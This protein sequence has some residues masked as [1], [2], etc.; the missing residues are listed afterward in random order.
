[1]FHLSAG[2]ARA[3]LPLS[4]LNDAGARAVA[5]F[6]VL[7]CLVLAVLSAQR[8]QGPTP[9]PA[10]S[11]LS[12]FSAQR[13]LRHVDAIARAPHP[14]GSAAHRQVRDYLQATLRDMGLQVETQSALVANRYRPTGM[15][16]VFAPV[17]NIVATLPGNA[18]TPGRQADSLLLMA[19]YD[20]AH[21]TP[22][23]SDDAAGVA[24]ILE[25]VRALSRDAHRPR[26][27]VVLLSDGEELGLLGAQAFFDRHRVASRVG[28]VLNFEARGSGGPVY[29]FQTGPGAGGLIDAL[30]REVPAAQSN[31]LLQSIYEVMPNN[32]DLSIALDAK[33]PGMN[34]AFAEHAFD[35]HA[36]TDT[37]E[38]LDPASLQHMGD[39]ALPLARRFV[40]SGIPPRSAAGS[41]FVLPGIGLVHYPFAVDLAALGVSLL[42]IGIAVRRQRH[43]AGLR[44][45]DLAR[46]AGIALL[47]LAASVAMPSLMHQGVARHLGGGMTLETM[48]T[49][50]AQE[51]GWY[52]AWSLMALGAGLWTLDRARIGL[53]WRRALATSTVALAVLPLLWGAFM[54]MAF[55]AAAAMGLALAWLMRKPLPLQ[56]GIAG[57]LIVSAMLVCVIALYLRG[58]LPVFGW[59]LL[60]AAIAASMP[61][62]IRDARNVATWALAALPASFLFGTTSYLLGVAVGAIVPAAATLPLVLALLLAAPLAL[63][64]QPR[65]MGAA[66][67]VAATLWVAVLGLREPF[68]ARHPRPTSLFVLQ[69]ADAGSSAWASIDHALIP[70]HRQ[71]LGA[72]PRVVDATAPFPDFPVRTWLAGNTLPMQAPPDLALL[73]IRRVD[74]A[75]RVALRLRPGACADET[76]LFVPPGAALRGWRVQDQPFD[77]SSVETSGWSSMTGYALPADGVEIALDF[78][79]GA[80]LPAVI[81]TSVCHRLP[82]GARLP[83]R[84]A[85]MMARPYANDGDTV[86]TRRI[87]LSSGATAA[88]QAAPAVR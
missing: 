72:S 42:L 12:G 55:A 43:A 22:G 58:A 36:P 31:S 49:L 54:P 47:A 82:A 35:Y 15:G 17:E 73:G 20:S 25:T 41:Y 8:W 65:R 56:A 2:H 40:T 10:D 84:T 13:A 68:D 51:R 38:R 77:A 81:A 87:A 6:L 63:H 28:L 70:W 59:P 32:T 45:R 30:R 23:A 29:M 53:S 18:G 26:D 50:L 33:R 88:A 1:M 9:V 64:H 60:A 62:S 66:M 27:V 52:G 67:V 5:P 19:H 4:R 44:R 37:V 71:V 61:P 14:V 3:P 24:T 21:T 75:Q 76:H 16:A 78:A 34:F 57:A 46:G 74:S 69:D 11:P 39:N 79:A 83:P 86:V 85:A 48:W 7:V 80:P